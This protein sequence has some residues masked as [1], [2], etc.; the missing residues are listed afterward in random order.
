MK[1]KYVIQCLNTKMYFGGTKNCGETLLWVEKID[2]VFDCYFSEITLFSSEDAAIECL[3]G[4]TFEGE[5]GVYTI[6]KIFINK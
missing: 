2:G 4:I 6:L 1:K 3:N 5:Y